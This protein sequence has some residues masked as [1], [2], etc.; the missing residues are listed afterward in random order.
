MSDPFHD[1]WPSTVEG[2]RERF[3]ET[4]K[5]RVSEWP[6]ETQVEW[7]E[8]AG[9]IEDGQRLAR[10]TAEFIAYWRMRKGKR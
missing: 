2:S 1:V 7:E 5:A 8:L 4:V 9:T 10:H 3:R 6:E